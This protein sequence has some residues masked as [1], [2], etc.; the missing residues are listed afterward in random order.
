MSNVFSSLASGGY[1]E[2]H[3]ICFPCKSPDGT[4]AGT[5]LEKWQNMMVAGL[6]NLGGDFEKVKE[7]KNYMTEAGFVDVIEKRYTWAIGPWVRGRKQK[8]WATCKCLEKPP[9][10]L[11]CLQT[12]T[13]TLFQCSWSNQSCSC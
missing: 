9:F 2:L 7:Y 13:E 5:A 6:K 3:D 1:F 10:A 12:L 11:D 4:T 8:L